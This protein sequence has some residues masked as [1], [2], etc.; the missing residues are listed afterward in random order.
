MVE[1][2]SNGQTAKVTGLKGTLKKTKN[3]AVLGRAAMECI[4]LGDG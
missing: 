4:H 1:K 2:V 3:G